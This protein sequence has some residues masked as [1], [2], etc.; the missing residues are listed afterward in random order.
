MDEAFNSYIRVR[1]YYESLVIPGIGMGYD[2]TPLA[3]Y[4]DEAQDA[5][6]GISSAVQNWYTD[7]TSATYNPLTA[8]FAPWSYYFEQIRRA[9]LFLQKIQD[10]NIITFDINEEEKQGW[11]ATVRV[12][13]AYYYLQIIKR[14]GG[15]PIFE[16]PYEFNHDFTN[17]KRAT[18]EECADFILSECDKALTIPEPASMAIGF[19]W[20]VGNSE[21]GA[22]T[23]GFAYA[24]KSQ[25]A[26]YAASPLW[27]TSGSKYSWEKAEQITKE[28]LDQCLMH[29]YELYNTPVDASIA[30]NPYTYYFIQ[31]SDPDRSMDKETIYESSTQM[32]VWNQCGTPVT[33]GMTK[34]GACPSQELIDSYEMANGIQPISGYTDAD[35]LNPIINPSSGYDPANPYLNRDPRF[36]GSVYYNMSPRTLGGTSYNII[37]NIGWQNALSSV[38]IDDYVKLTTTSL[39]DP[40]IILTVDPAA[41]HHTATSVVFSFEYKSNRTAPQFRLIFY[42]TN[43]GGLTGDAYPA[44]PAASEWTKVEVDIT[45]HF[46]GAPVGFI[47]FGIWPGVDDGGGTFEINI[48]NQHLYVLKNIQQVETFVNGNCGISNRTTDVRFTRTGYY[49]RKFNHNQ[50]GSSGNNDGYMKIF[51]LGELYLNFAE[52]AYQAHGT[53]YSVPSA[54]S[55][56]KN[57]SALE[58]VNA[59]RKRAGIVELVSGMTKDEFEKRYRNERRVELAFEEHRFFDV[60]RWK[61]LNETD[62]FVTGMRITKN[63]DNSFTYNRIKLANRGTNTDKYLLYPIDQSEVLKMKE[64]TGISWQNPGW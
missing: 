18:F 4:C 34:A 50:S 13:R 2:N 38:E 24:I 52:A 43:I 3:S 1:S 27:F 8:S 30:Q 39:A 14:Y 59:I 10:P 21:R 58:A 54:V 11:I 47:N 26:L 56:G 6:D 32:N 44:L 7:K 23:R 33:E 16:E 41:D 35:H 25:T 29:G 55:G 48:K 62:N 57:L 19:R 12:L 63:T 42:D 36:Y 22:I 17:D 45:Q 15:A 40:Y 37:F 51:R 61:I 60:R 9:G 49:L 64:F 53:D 28:A 20:R 46:K 5:S 31:R